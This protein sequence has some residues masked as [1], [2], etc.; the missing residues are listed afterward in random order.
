MNND[1]KSS[2]RYVLG[3]FAV[4][5]IKIS[6]FGMSVIRRIDSGEITIAE[7]KQLIVN[8]AKKL[9]KKDRMLS[10]LPIYDYAIPS[11]VLIYRLNRPAFPR[12]FIQSA[13][14]LSLNDGCLAA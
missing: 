11:F 8:E 12:E 6:D 9:A 7:G 10:H 3:L 2:T 4:D 13:S 5:S 1:L 14:S